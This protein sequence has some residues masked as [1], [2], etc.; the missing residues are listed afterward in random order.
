MDNVKLALTMMMEK[1]LT[2]SSMLK[3]SSLH[4]HHFHIFT[5]ILKYN[6]K[7]NLNSNAVK[8]GEFPLSV[9][10]CSS[11]LHCL[12]KYPF[13]TFFLPKTILSFLQF[14]ILFFMIFTQ[15]RRM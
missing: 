3:N 7:P 14:L 10:T 1:K 4:S 15:L 11:V 9:S 6:F 5:C 2:N 13:S 12:S 8:F